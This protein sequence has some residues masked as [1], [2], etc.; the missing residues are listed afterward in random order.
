M[1]ID[2][3]AIIEMSIHSNNNTKGYRMIR[4]KKREGEEK[5]REAAA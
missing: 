2:E 5:D 4:R 1:R 3:A